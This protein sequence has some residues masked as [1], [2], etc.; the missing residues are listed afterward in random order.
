MQDKP[1][2]GTPALRVAWGTFRQHCY[3][4]PCATWESGAR[5]Y[6]SQVDIVFEECLG[7]TANNRRSEPGN[8]ILGI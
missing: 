8:L 4:T 2:A 3:R 5:R 1:A 7:V 6:K